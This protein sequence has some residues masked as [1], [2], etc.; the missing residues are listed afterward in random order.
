MYRGKFM[1]LWGPAKGW[2][3]SYRCHACKELM[4]KKE[5]SKSP[6]YINACGHITCAKCIV[7]S[8][9][10]DHNPLCPVKDCGIYID[11]KMNMSTPDTSENSVAIVKSEECLWGVCMCDESFAKENDKFE[12]EYNYMEDEESWH[13]CGNWL[14]P[15][16]CGTLVCGCIDVCRGKCGASQ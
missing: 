6:Q 12:E 15:G 3:A 10:I 13:Y 4:T 9:F 11:P 2:L 14:C 7:K 16:D 5:A 1:D 8:Y